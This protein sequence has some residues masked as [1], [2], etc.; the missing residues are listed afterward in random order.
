MK[1]N[2]ANAVKEHELIDAKK[3]L[4]GSSTKKKIKY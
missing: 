3:R 1:K 4:R 2:A